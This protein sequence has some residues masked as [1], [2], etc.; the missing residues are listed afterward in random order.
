MRAIKIC[1][2]KEL[3][4]D[5]LDVIFLHGATGAT[6]HS[7]DH[8][9]AAAKP[10][11]KVVIDIETSTP[12]AKVVTDAL[13]AAAFFDRSS[14]SVSTRQP[15]AIVSKEK[16]SDLTVPWI[17]PAVDICQELWQFSH[18]TVGFAGR[19]LIAGGLLAFGIIHQQLLLMIAGM[20]FLPLLPI[21]MGI[22]FGAWTRDR[23]LA[24]R[25]AGAMAI[26]LALLVIAGIG[27]GLLSQPPVKYDDFNSLPVSLI[28]SFAVGVAA[29]LAN[30]DDG[31]RREL[32][33]L[34]AT[35]QIAVIPVWLG[36]CTVLGLPIAGGPADV[37]LKIVTLFLNILIVIAASLGT[38]LVLNAIGPWTKKPRS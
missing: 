20:L 24:G 6:V 12:T 3:S 4:A 18:V 19:V 23:G 10:Q 21:M 15:R 26:A 32:I 34:A 5:V 1:V 7:V 9:D 13:I 22:G 38:Y 14:C 2:P 11:D 35:A 8:F 25:A 31:G 36:V 37:P 33:G 29:A 30:T 16:F 28:I 27:V 17:E